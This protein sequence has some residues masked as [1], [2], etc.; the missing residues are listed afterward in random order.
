MNICLCV[1]EGCDLPAVD[2]H[3]IKRMAAESGVE[4]T[5]ERDPSLAA[6]GASA[7]YTDVWV[8]MGQDSDL[9]KIESLKPYQLN[10]ELLAKALPEAIVMHC[11]PAHRGDEITDEAMDGPRS[12]VFDQAENRLHAQK[13]LLAHL[14]R[15]QV[16]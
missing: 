15:A 7:L 2:W 5:L 3:R 10:A 13:A 11:L 16:G 9:T 8:S 6:Q 12:V 14:V 4:A 1:P